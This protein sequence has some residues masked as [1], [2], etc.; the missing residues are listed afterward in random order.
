[1]VVG[2][3]SAMIFL[4]MLVFI[5]L[6]YANRGS[7]QV[8]E[9]IKP[10][11]LAVAGAWVYL[12]FA[13]LFT[14]PPK[15]EHRIEV[16]LF[17]EPG[18]RLLRLEFVVE[19]VEHQKSQDSLRFIMADWRQK[20]T[21]PDLT[22]HA[23]SLNSFEETELFLDLLELAFFE[24]L[25]QEYSGH[26]D[27]ERIVDRGPSGANWRIQAC[28]DAEQKVKAIP[29][30]KVM[31]LLEENRLVKDGVRLGY[32]RF[33]GTEG[34]EK[35]LETRQKI[36]MFEG[37]ILPVGATI[38]VS[39]ERYSRM[40]SI[41]TQYQNFRIVLKPLFAVMHG[42]GAKGLATKL[43]DQLRLETE[44][45]SQVVIEAFEVSFQHQRTRFLQWAPLAVRQAAWAN[46][47][48]QLF[49]TYF[50]WKGMR[51]DLEKALR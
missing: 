17:R 3:L 45:R 21:R 40:I 27:V 1:M 18:Q 4:S 7:E 2:L 16:L 11:V 29:L 31:K 28:P 5:G 47:M 50:G 35:Q 26:W 51:E 39:H 48:A 10:M 20:T 6:V 15:E 34:W 33:E 23:P 42:L 22:E 38:T 30:S 37:F 44:K 25:S 24:W 36:G 12:A 46:Q 8:F 19:E 49:D 41:K 13:V 9:I 43:S 32:L 14:P